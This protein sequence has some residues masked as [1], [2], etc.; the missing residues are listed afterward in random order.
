MIKVL[1]ALMNIVFVCYTLYL[2][3]PRLKIIVNDSDK[4]LRKLGYFAIISLGI[5]YYLLYKVVNVIV[6]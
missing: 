1:F 5:S 6:S 3:V 2:N 4:D